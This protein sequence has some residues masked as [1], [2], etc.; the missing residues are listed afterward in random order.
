MSLRIGLG[1]DRHRLVPG[2]GLPLGGLWVPSANGVDA[3][4]DGDVLL[5]ALVDA[6]LGAIGQGDIGDRFPPTEERWKDAASA[7]FLDA[8]LQDVR[9]RYRIVNID[10]TVFLQSTRLGPHKQSIAESV[11]KLCD[12]P[13]GVVNVKAK[14]GEAVGPVGTDAAVE[15]AV[16]VLLETAGGMPP[17]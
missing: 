4:S 2:E 1:F 3:H 12:L 15:A 9:P 16:A 17:H 13:S 7:L 8:V 6:L 10:A 11:A 5:H 14:T